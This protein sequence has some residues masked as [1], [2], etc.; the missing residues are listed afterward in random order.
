MLFVVVVLHALLKIASGDE[1]KEVDAAA[2]TYSYGADV[3][4]PAQHSQVTDSEK[5][6]GESIT[7]FYND[8]LQG[9]REYY[10]D[11][12]AHCD[13]SERSRLNLNSQQPSVMQ[14][15]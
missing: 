3:S 10:K 2:T 8:F 5:P 14:V 1:Q 11:R 4:F 6:F 15:S 13:E 9:C 12:S 7:P